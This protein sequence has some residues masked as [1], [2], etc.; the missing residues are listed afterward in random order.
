MA[1]EASP[2]GKVLDFELVDASGRPAWLEVKGWTAKTWRAQLDAI[3]NGKGAEKMEHLFAQLDTAKAT[4]NPSYLA[5]TD[6]LD[7][8]T[9]EEIAQLLRA[10]GYEADLMYFSESALKTTARE[11]CKALAIGAGVG[12]LVDLDEVTEDD[13]DSSDN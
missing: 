3:A 10:R 12:A 11:L 13:Q 2:A 8:G 4:G 6:A 7:A 5:I 9:R 1:D